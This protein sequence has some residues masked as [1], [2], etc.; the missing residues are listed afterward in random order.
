MRGR[1][2]N[3]FQEQILQSLI[4]PLSM[5]LSNSYQVITKKGDI[6]ALHSMSSWVKTLTW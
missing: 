1:E 3:T 6:R 4:I 2:P 5:L